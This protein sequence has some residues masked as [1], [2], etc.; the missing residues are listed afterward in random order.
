MPYDF[1]RH[2]GET[3]QHLLRHLLNARPYV[4]WANLLVKLTPGL[5]LTSNP[6]GVTLILVNLSTVVIN[7]N[8]YSNLVGLSLSVTS[9]LV[10][11]L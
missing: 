6:S 4:N 11:Y 5:I 9:T 2:V 3:E 8:C 1:S 7:F 10:L